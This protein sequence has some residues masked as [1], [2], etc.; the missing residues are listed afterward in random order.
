M[1][2]ALIVPRAVVGFWVNSFLGRVVAHNT[3]CVERPLAETGRSIRAS[4]VT[5][6][7]AVAFV[8]LVRVVNKIVLSSVCA[9]K[10]AAVISW[11]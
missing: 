5:A 4:R 10:D 2:P 11:Q 1:R 6:I 3:C 7:F 9:W 8:R